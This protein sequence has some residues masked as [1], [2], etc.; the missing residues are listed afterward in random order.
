MT[1]KIRPLILG[2]ASTIPAPAPPA[3]V[4]TPELQEEWRAAAESRIRATEAANLRGELRPDERSVSR[5]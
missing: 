3:P 5:D 1:Q 4:T 2:K